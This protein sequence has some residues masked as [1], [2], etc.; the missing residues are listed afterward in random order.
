MVEKRPER[1]LDIEGPAAPPRKN[2]ELV[3]AAPW[4]SRIFAMAVALHEQGVFEWDEFREQLIAE[5]GAWERRHGT[6]AEWSYYARWQAA[7]ETLLAHKQVCPATEL[8]A[9]EQTLNAR[10]PGHDH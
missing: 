1:V 7:L 8:N 10:P 9:R 6:D 5:I 3:F 4:E 2:G